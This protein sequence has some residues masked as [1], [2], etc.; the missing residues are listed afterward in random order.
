MNPPTRPPG[1]EP[2]TDQ[3]TPP[4][5]ASFTA[6]RPEQLASLGQRLAGAFIDGFL[7]LATAVPILSKTVL[8]GITEPAQITT[9]LIIQGNLVHLA[10]YLGLHGYLLHKNGQTVGKFLVGSKIRFVD[11][12]KPSLLHII[13]MRTFVPGLLGLIPRFGVFLVAAGTALILKPDRRALHDHIAGTV[14]V[15]AETPDPADSTPS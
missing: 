1:Q 15:K 12:R 7:Q 3:S 4:A 5:P 14:V 11:G 10:V 13:V 8:A 2:E 6:Y 9:G